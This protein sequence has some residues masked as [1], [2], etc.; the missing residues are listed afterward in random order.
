MFSLPLKNIGDEQSPNVLLYSPP[1]RK[2]GVYVNG[3]VDSELIYLGSY[4]FD[5]GYNVKI[6]DGYFIGNDVY[7]VN[8]I[9][10]NNFLI[11]DIWKNEY[12]LEGLWEEVFDKLDKVKKSNPNIKVICI[13][14]IS[15]LLSSEIL[16]RYDFIDYVAGQ[17]SVDSRS[18][19]NEL[20]ASEIQSYYSSFPELSQ[21]FIS[22][23][24]LDLSESSTVSLI[25]SRGCQKKC[26]FCSYNAH[27]TNWKERP[28]AKLA[29]DIAL[30][31]VTFGAS[32]FALSDNNFGINISDNK[33]RIQILR[34][35]L[36]Q[37]RLSPQLALN[38]SPDGL[39]KELLDL[40]AET[41][42]T[43]VLLGVESFSS[44]TRKKLYNKYIN[45]DN[46]I[47][48]VIYMQKLNIKPVLSHILFHPFLSLSDLKYELSWIKQFGPHLFPHFL[49]NSKLQIIPNTPIE[50]QIHAKGLL[51]SDGMNRDFRFQFKEVE[52][53]FNLLKLFFD[54][55]YQSHNS[56]IDEL[57][58]LRQKEWRLVTS[59]V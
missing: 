35:E 3:T 53:L 33:K 48:H 55:N 12:L 4:L 38:I 43:T 15:S 59:L 50:K 58:S 52:N 5:K 57:A 16:A 22:S 54:G 2:K 26:S 18:G 24:V 1:F 37:A 13:G 44:A 30:F 17:A 9:Q 41:G 11:V 20:I 36:K 49:V 21:G 45:I 25:S 28:I 6:V 23:L 42:V 14:S 19:K 29:Q 31:N 46:L 47:D 8:H 32:K 27:L 34:D 51:V 7:L 10:N 39:D 56:S 40:F